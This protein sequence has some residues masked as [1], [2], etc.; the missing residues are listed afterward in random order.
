MSNSSFI[1]HTSDDAESIESNSSEIEITSPKL[2]L[3]TVTTYTLYILLWATV[4]AIAVHL[5]FGT[6]YFIVSILYAIWINTRTGPKKQ[7]EI[8]AYSVFNPNCEAIDG[9]L[10]AE[11]FEQEIRYGA[12][13]VH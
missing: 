6:V 3:F 1:S 10:K 5:E 4:Y 13:S 7:G 11:Q 2:T 8:S 9:T 12:G